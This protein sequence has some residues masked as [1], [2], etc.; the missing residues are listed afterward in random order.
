MPIRVPWLIALLLA[1]AAAWALAPGTPVDASLVEARPI[2]VAR[3]GQG[4]RGAAGPSLAGRAP[5]VAEPVVATPAASPPLVLRA[6]EP[7]PEGLPLHVR[8]IEAETGREVILPWRVRR[9]AKDG[10][11]GDLS[12]V[13]GVLRPE[14]PRA[15]PARPGEVAAFGLEIGE[16]SA[17]RLVVW[18]ARHWTTQVSIYAT[19]L[20]V[21][22]PLRAE[23]QVRVVAT[24]HKGASVQRF[25]VEGFRV[26]GQTVSDGVR[27]TPAADGRRVRGVPYFRGQ[28]LEVLAIPI[29]QDGDEADLE[30]VHIDCDLTEEPVTVGEFDLED[31]S[32]PDWVPGGALGRARFP[33]TPW[34]P[35]LI[36]VRFPEDREHGVLW[37]FSRSFTCGSRCGGGRRVRKTGHV[38]VTVLRRDGRPAEG[39]QVRLRGRTLRADA[40]GVARFENVREGA[41]RAELQEPGLVAS[42]EAFDVK[43]GETVRATLREAQGGT[44]VVRVLAHD[45]EP[46]PC[47]AVAL[48]RWAHWAELKAG[49]QRL[50]PYSD[51]RGVRVL[52]RVPAGARRV[53]AT[54]AGLSKTV[55][56]QVRDGLRAYA[57]ITLPAPSEE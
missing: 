27:S 29:P 57:T 5:R 30:E 48:S 12:R 8:F 34:E 44:L 16:A 20:E 45:G 38:E 43:P 24:D 19:A 1:M 40:R 2:G 11:S 33:A 52:E 10:E 56:V 37:G 54:W 3:A 18:D 50:D 35:L 7:E 32:D 55:P 39:A 23:A 22:Y 9:P 31:L 53:T 25:R 6:E 17:Q 21:V 26:A 28:P 49:V 51:E 4:L 42:G 13:F 15:S 47:A 41:A 46:A 14:T 36:R